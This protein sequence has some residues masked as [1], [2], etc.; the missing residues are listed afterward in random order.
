MKKILEN[1]ILWECIGYLNLLMCIVGQ[2][3]VGYWY[4]L[5]QGVYLFANILAVIRCFAFH[6]PTSDKVKNITFT[7][8][9]IGLIIIYVVR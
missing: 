2:I 6:L 4:L 8:I 3:T 7:A 5:A 9:T 1:K